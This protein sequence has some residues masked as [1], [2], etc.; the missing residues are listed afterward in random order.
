M[1]WVRI[2]VTTSEEASEAI[3]NY[4]FEIEAVGIE[5]KG[6]TSKHTNIIAY[7]PLNDRVNSR[8]KKLRHFISLLPSWGIESNTTKIEL[9]DVK[10]QD[11]DQT[12][13]SLYVPQKIGD[14]LHIIPTWHDVSDNMDD[15]QIRID[16]GMAFGTGYH[17]TTRLSLRLIEKTIKT[18]DIVADIGTG[19]GILSIAAIKLGASH[20]DAIE[21]DP[22][23]IPVAEENFRN[24]SVSS[25][26]S[27]YVGNVFGKVDKVYDVIVGNILT[28]TILPLIPNCT[29]RLKQDGSLIFS[30]VLDTELTLIKNTL[31]ENGFACYE[32]IEEKE[33]DVVWLGVLARFI[34]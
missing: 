34:S 8:V 13:K 11:W 28:K 1:N 22:S 4:F 21:I 32:V 20:V 29:S 16:P 27:L 15:I 3:A 6:S 24:N 9:E 18:D 10:S 7:F 12:W 31:T 25:Q 14:R 19:S 26:V 30:G 2:I 17:P 33:E 5:L 23:A